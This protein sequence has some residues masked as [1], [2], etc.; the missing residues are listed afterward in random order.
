VLLARR[1]DTFQRDDGLRQPVVFS[2]VRSQLVEASVDLCALLSQKISHVVLSD[3][4]HLQ[5]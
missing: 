2:D 3:R 4:C 5:E 1:R